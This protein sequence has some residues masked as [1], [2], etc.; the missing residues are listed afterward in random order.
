MLFLRGGVML[1]KGYF[2]YPIMKRISQIWIKKLICPPISTTPDKPME[3]RPKTKHTLVGEIREKLGK[4]RQ[5][6]QLASVISKQSKVRKGNGQTKS[7]VQSKVNAGTNLEEHKYKAEV[8]YK[9]NQDRLTGRDKQGR[10]C[11]ELG[12]KYYQKQTALCLW[13]SNRAPQL[14]NLLWANKAWAG[15]CL[16]TQ[17]LSQRGS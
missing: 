2:K 3:E 14:C 9:G 1:S 12:S 7:C 4:R 10:S 5:G 13:C 11:S 17:S 16:A 15:W 8:S 6:R